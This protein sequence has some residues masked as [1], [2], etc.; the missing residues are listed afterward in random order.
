MLEL[1]ERR[2]RSWER[3]GLAPARETYTFADL[4]VLRSLIRLHAGGASPAKI[5]RAVTALRQ[6]L[7][8]LPEPL[9]DL[10]I[11]C[12]RGRIAVQMGACRMEAMSGQ[13][14]LDFDLEDLHSLL[15]FPKKIAGDAVHAAEAARR[16]E[17]SIWFEKGLQMENAGA[18]LPDVIE[19]YEHALALD[20]HSAGAQ[21]NLGTI[22][23]HLKDY[24]R[25][26]SFYAGALESDPRYPLAHFNLG[27]LYD[28]R[29]NHEKA[30]L[31]YTLAVRLDPEYADAHYNLALLYQSTGQLMSAVRHWKA[32]LRIDPA[33]T[34]AA[35]ARQELDKLRKAT[36]IEGAKRRE[37][38]SGA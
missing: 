37:G 5:R 27:N 29:G 11:F 14:L 16:F 28:E 7:G 32:Y 24:S 22:Y 10:R 23:F 6:R 35:T 17:S 8:A 18:P 26:E 25:A 2:L 9:R 13:M 3:Q 30:L 33:S 31:H 34:W 36:V 20:P 12:E 4:V 1:S 38:A 21:V 15:A 19:T